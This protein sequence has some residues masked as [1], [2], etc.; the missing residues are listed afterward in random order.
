MLTMR[1]T[2]MASTGSE[3]RPSAH[4]LEV[5]SPHLRADARQAVT[6]GTARATQPSEPTRG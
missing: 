1:V 2:I 3:L 4:T 5:D 6:L